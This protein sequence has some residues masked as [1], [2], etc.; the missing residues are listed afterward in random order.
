M[1]GG[2]YV[3]S[4]KDW[5]F[6]DVFHKALCLKGNYRIDGRKSF[7]SI[8]YHNH[9]S[10]TAIHISGFRPRIK[11][12]RRNVVNIKLSKL[13]FGQIPVVLFEPNIV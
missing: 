10:C 13:L 5:D 9:G 12:T 3:L 2:G 1:K 8:I 7:T 4:I 6:L 11:G